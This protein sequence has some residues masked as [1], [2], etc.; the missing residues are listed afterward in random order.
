M[1][2]S[3]KNGQSK[4]ARNGTRTL[5]VAVPVSLLDKIKKLAKAERRS[6]NSKTGML[7]EQAVYTELARESR[8]EYEAQK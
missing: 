1:P 5:H 3:S 2:N 8:R 7:I 4:T 6:I